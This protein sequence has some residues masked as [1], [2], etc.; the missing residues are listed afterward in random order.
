MSVLV[1]P[2]PTRMQRSDGGHD[3]SDELAVRNGSATLLLDAS[4]ALD[5]LAMRML[6][7][8]APTIDDIAA[9]LGWWSG[10]LSAGADR[11]MEPVTP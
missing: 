8:D 6:T 5:D 1:G 4:E 2:R 9:E 11:A 7:G 3:M 10:W